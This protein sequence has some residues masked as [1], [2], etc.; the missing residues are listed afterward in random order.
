MADMQKLCAAREAAQALNLR[1]GRSVTGPGAGDESQGALTTGF[2]GI[3]HVLGVGG[4]PRGRIT[5]IY[6]GPSCGKTTLALQIIARTQRDG[7]QAAFIDAEHSFDPD[8]AAALG[9][10]VP[11]LYFSRP[12]SGE[13]A[14][15]ITERLAASRG[16]DLIVIDSAAALL[17]REEQEAGLS[18][19][20]LTAAQARMMSCCLRRLNVS[21]SRS[22]TALI[23]INQL[24]SSLAEAG[25]NGCPDVT[26]GGMALAFYAAVRLQLT[27]R[28]LLQEKDVCLGARIRLMARKNKLA[29]PYMYTELDCRFSRGFDILADLVDQGLET[30]VLQQ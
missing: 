20:K 4:I 3:D 7:G 22:G 30:G 25:M 12:D 9:V 16:I 13:M 6:G 1:F 17:P 27:Q 24:R 8:Y 21:L 19:P 23:F 14:L 26:S 15:S 5:E 10:D 29:V 11:Q 28:E 18:D 2:A